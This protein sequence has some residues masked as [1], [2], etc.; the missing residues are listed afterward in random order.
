MGGRKCLGVGGR[1][2]SGVGM[3]EVSGDGRKES[4]SWVGVRLVLHLAEGV[5]WPLARH[6]LQG[7]AVFTL[8]VSS[9][10]LP[11]ASHL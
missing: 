1:R 8:P 9:Y 7:P 3:D 10:H 6:L 4:V 2:S 5:V 11:P